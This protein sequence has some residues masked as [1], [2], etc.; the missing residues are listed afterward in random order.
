M[1]ERVLAIACLIIVAAPA[2]SAQI[3]WDVGAG[4]VMPTGDYGDTDKTGVSGGVAGTSWLTGGHLG[5]RAEFSYTSTRETSGITP[6]KTTLIGGMVSVVYGL[7]LAGASVRPYVLGGLGVSSGKVT[8]PG[9]PTGSETK[10][11][12]GGGAGVSFRMGTGGSRIFAEARYMSFAGA[13]ALTYVPIIVGI[14]FG[15]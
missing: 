7:A 4:L 8:L 9:V 6:H 2:A 3:R 5:M 13:R 14:S 15:Q 11:A 10:L 1:F 12:F